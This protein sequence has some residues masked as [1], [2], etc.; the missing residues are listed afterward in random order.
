M[1]IISKISAF[2]LP[3]SKP[4]APEELRDAVKLA[5]GKA[6][7]SPM[8]RGHPFP[9]GRAFALEVGYTEELLASLPSGAS[10]C[11]VGVSNVSLYSDIKH[12][13]VVLDI[14]CG[15]GLDLMIAAV[16]AGSEGRAIGIDF[17]QSMIDKARAF[18]RELKLK[19]VEIHLADAER[20]PVGDASVDVIIA[21]GIFNLNPHRQEVFSECHRVLKKGGR[22]YASE[23]VLVGPA[24]R[25]N[26]DACSLK[27]WFA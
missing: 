23:L 20:L 8:E 1:G 5:Y 17:S 2:F 19:N 22:M 10:D 7:E 13:D 21:N 9:V 24:A 12:G 6:A 14:G 18:V 11:F 4:A 25:T 26:G 15:A 16:R 3:R 27:D